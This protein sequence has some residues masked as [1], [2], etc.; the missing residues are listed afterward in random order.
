MQLGRF[1][2]FYWLW[3]CR[4]PPSPHPDTALPCR[5]DIHH[6]GKSP[7]QG[8]FMA[9]PHGVSSQ[10]PG[11][12]T[13][14]QRH[15]ASHHRLDSGLGG[16][17][18]K[19][20]K[21]AE[22]LLGLSWAAYSPSRWQASVWLLESRFWGHKTESALLATNMGAVCPA[23]QELCRNTRSNLTAKINLLCPPVIPGSCSLDV[24][25]LFTWVAKDACLFRWTDG[26][27]G[28]TSISR[29]GWCEVSRLAG[30]PAQPTRRPP[31]FPHPAL[32]QHGRPSPAR[33]VFC[34]SCCSTAI[35]LAQQPLPPPGGR[36]PSQTAQPRQKSLDKIG[37]RYSQNLGPLG[38]KID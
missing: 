7:N 27:P 34:T 29:L 32:C 25:A 14:S 18:K 19:E 8:A 2:E 21:K 36:V 30:S 31:W 38:E 9:E 4:N 26:L 6:W 15:P 13:S 17:E 1:P 28:T 35:S 24:A 5:A 33:L 23:P 10:G 3:Q 22:G 16:E 12:V 11:H 20:R 37:Q